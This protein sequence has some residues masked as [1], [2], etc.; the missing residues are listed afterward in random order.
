MKKFLT[1][2]AMAAVATLTVACFDKITG[3][4]IINDNQNNN[5]TPTPSPSATPAACQVTRLALGT[6]NDDFE[7]APGE[8]VKLSL[9]LYNGVTE[10]ASVCQSQVSVTFDTPT[11][12]CGPVEG[13]WFDAKLRANSTA[14]S[15]Q[16][17]STLARS[18]SVV[19]DTVTIAV[20]AP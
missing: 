3:P 10:L 13:A 12:P 17:C 15:G 1:I 4:T 14:T 9:S 19:S 11:G 20:V 6:V 8:A 16:S 2:L 7:F 5:G 18:G